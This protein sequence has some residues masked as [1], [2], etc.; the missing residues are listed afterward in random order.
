MEVV[1]GL[2]LRGTLMA[3]GA[4]SRLKARMLLKVAVAAG[5]LDGGRWMMG[6]A[7]LQGLGI[8]KRSGASGSGRSLAIKATVRTTIQQWGWIGG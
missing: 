6:V 7:G 5:I 8:L 3:T 2:F 1:G 4:I